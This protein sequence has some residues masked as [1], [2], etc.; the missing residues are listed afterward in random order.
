M[1][2]FV[3]DGEE[4]K[5]VQKQLRDARDYIDH[6]LNH[7]PEQRARYGSTGDEENT[8]PP[9]PPFGIVING[10]SLV[11]EGDVAMYMPTVFGTG[12]FSLGYWLNIY[13]ETSF[14]TMMIYIAAWPEEAYGAVAVG[15][16]QPM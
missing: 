3:I 4:Y 8:G 15:D 2:L 16:G 14:K 13:R 9:G 5:E 11:S 7:P 10:H 6:V 1:H 12:G